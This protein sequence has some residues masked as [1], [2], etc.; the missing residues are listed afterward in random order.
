MKIDPRHLEIISAIVDEGGLTEGAQALGKSQPSVS[1]TVTMLEERVGVSLFQKNKRPLQPTELCL[2]LAAEGRRIRQAGGSAA[3]IIANYRGGR[4]GLVRIAGTPVFMDGVISAFV[5]RFQQDFP[6]VQIEQSYGYA[7]ELTAQ[8][9]SGAL[10]L[11]ICPMNAS[12]VGPDFEF[13]SMME[14]RNVIACGYT[15]P[16]LSRKSLKLNDIAPYPWVAPPATSPLYNDMRQVLSDIGMRD[17]K[18]SFSGGSL[19]AT[20]NI[21]MNSEALTVLPYSVVF[22]ARK[23]RT[24]SALSVRLGHPERSL[25]ILI[26]ARK[27]ERPSAKRFI[28][29]LTN[30]FA[31]LSERIVKQD[32]NAVWRG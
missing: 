10:D 25:G 1:R 20:T 3:G 24:L 9:E 8:L 23:Q 16:L 29:F 28:R 5:A 26:H 13:T 7:S 30:E 32:Q 27:L 22:M 17:F 2:A 21:L 15:H 19:S 6:D 12:S 14:G 31:S 4:R 18:V 11:A